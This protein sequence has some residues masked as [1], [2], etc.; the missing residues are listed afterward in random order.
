MYALLVAGAKLVTGRSHAY[1]TLRAAGL[2]S[3]TIDLRDSES[4]HHVIPVWYRGDAELEA[5]KA[6]LRPGDVYI[7]VGANYGAYALVIA[8]LQGVR[9]IAVEPQPHVAEA[10]RRS[11]L[12]NG[13]SN[14]EVVQAALAAEAGTA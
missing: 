10:L 13:F 1:A 14:F 3:L 11:A 12:A 2:P 5:V 4:F 9:V 8:T 6:V 7:D